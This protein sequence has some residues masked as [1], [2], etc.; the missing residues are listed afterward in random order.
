VQRPPLSERYG[1]D[2]TTNHAAVGAAEVFLAGAEN[3]VVRNRSGDKYK[4]SVIKSYRRS[5]ALYIERELGFKQLDRIRKSDLQAVVDLMGLRLSP[6]TIRN[7]ANALR[8]LHRWAEDRDIVRINPTVGLRLRA[9]RSERKVA[10]TPQMVAQRIAAFPK[11][12]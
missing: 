12:R 2:G 11:V 4:P 6:S 9:V 1:D 8:G 3:G 7:M 10:L 5:L